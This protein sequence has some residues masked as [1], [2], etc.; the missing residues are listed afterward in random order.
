MRP[1]I[2]AAKVRLPPPRRDGLSR[3]HLHASL[4]T[5]LQK[6]LTLVSAPAG[7]G[8]TT[9]V[10]AWAT[11]L[12][13]PVVWLSLEAPES[14]LP[15]FMR[16]LHAA[17]QVAVPALAADLLALSEAA[18]PLTADHAATALLQVVQAYGAPLVLVLHDY[19][20]IQADAVHGLLTALL[21]HQP[22]HLHLVITTRED[23]PLPLARLRA[24]NELHEVRAADL[25]FSAEEAARFLNEVMGLDLMPA[26]A[27]ALAARTEG[28]ITGLQLAA[29]SMRGQPDRAGFL[30]AFVGSDRYL[31]DY[32]VE[33][34]LNRQPRALRQFLLHTSV[35]EGL[36]GAL[37]DAVTGQQ[38]GQAHLDTLERKHFFLVSL[39]EPGQ[40]F[41]Y[42]QLLAEALRAQ[43]AAEQPALLPLLHTRASHWFEAQG[44]AAEA[45]RH[46]LA[47]QNP[48][49]AADLIE[50]AVPEWRRTLQDGAIL[51]WLEALPA[52]LLRRRPVLCVYFAKALLQAGRWHEVEGRL[53]GAEQALRARDPEA[54][55]V[56][57]EAEF[58]RLPA[59]I[60]AYRAA[61]AVALGELGPATQ[62][63]AQVLAL[64]PPED[65]LACG[66]AAGFLGLTA[67][68]QG[69]LA[70]ASR[71]WAEAQAQLL[72]AGHLADAVGAALAQTEIFMARG[73]LRQA[74]RVSEQAL[75]VAT[76]GHGPPLRGTADLYVSLSEVFRQRHNLAA[77]RAALQ[78]SRALGPLSA[79]SSYEG[80]W[81]LAQAD[82]E[83]TEGRLPAALTLLAEAAACVQ[84]GDFPEGRPVPAVAARAQIRQGNLEA[85]HA[86]V[87][88]SGVSIRD[89]PSYLREYEQVTLVRVLLQASDTGIAA[90]REV[91]A[92]LQQLAA[93][94][95]AGGRSG[96]L[97]ELLILQALAHDQ[98]GQQAPALTFLERALDLAEPEGYAAVFLEEGAVMADLLRRV[99]KRGV[100]PSYVRHLLQG[101]RGSGKGLRSLPVVAGDLRLSTREQTVLRWL[102]TE[103][104]GPDIARELGVSI[105]TLRTHTQRV[106]DKLGVNSRRAA[107]RRAQT[108]GLI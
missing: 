51:P 70:E 74:Q 40:W 38:G 24:R 71:H 76:S 102:T 65:H 57:D 73:Q 37:C 26:Q 107:V 85:A 81:R 16:H 64:A 88:A 31:L 101:V 93:A 14:D 44:M 50:L 2:P 11:A 3:P 33:E 49:R 96:S 87:R 46:A 5:G 21:E 12:A 108:L 79:R 48:D 43:L 106:Y 52:A 78:H 77:A 100:A 23:P 18:G 80:R 98:A 34:V 47:A 59:E 97:I 29:L 94:A 6:K 83:L 89:E 9:L 75:Q 72:Q 68:R 30:R 27:A 28:W 4:N 36:N 92:F 103:L 84:P 91:L 7:Y 60:A 35:L 13:Q 54:H 39:D 90:R 8:K 58:R 95:E 61:L 63:A 45:I 10:S 55:V 41:R 20:A 32:L 53:R 69:K 86:W 104:S 56:V 42:H 105:N 17:L 19:H 62:H 15:Q 99:L 22:P 82:L 1:A 66:A 25:Q 67:W